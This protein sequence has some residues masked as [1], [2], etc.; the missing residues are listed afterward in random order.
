M[1]NFANTFHVNKMSDDLEI[2]L[3]LVYKQ[4]LSVQEKMGCICLFFSSRIFTNL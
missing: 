3:Q 2:F 4:E 1:T